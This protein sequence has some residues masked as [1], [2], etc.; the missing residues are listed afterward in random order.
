MI[1][2]LFLVTF[3][4]ALFLMIKG[5]DDERMVYS[6]VSTFLLVVT[7]ANALFIE[8]PETGTSYLDWAIG[9]V[10]FALILINILHVVA[11]IFED[12][13]NQKYRIW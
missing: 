4:I 13:I 7:M 12:R 3:I 9:A 10:C 6:W 5:I 8:I 2:S 11:M 1:E